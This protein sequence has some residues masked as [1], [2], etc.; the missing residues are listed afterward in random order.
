VERVFSPEGRFYY[1]SV[2]SEMPSG[3]VDR[4]RAREFTSADIEAYDGAFY[5]RDR[6]SN[7]ITR[8][9]VSADLELV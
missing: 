4:S 6:E 5:L 2:V 1:A 7:T 8:F 3:P 9:T